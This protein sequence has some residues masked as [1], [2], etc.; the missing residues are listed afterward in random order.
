MLP[1][2]KRTRA[3]EGFLLEEDLLKRVFIAGGVELLKDLGSPLVG[4]EVGVILE[5]TLS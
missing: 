1:S 3:E 2:L 5:S 4:E